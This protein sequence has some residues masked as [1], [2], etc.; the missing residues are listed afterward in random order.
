[1]PDNSLNENSLRSVSW[2][3]LAGSATLHV[4][5]VMG[6]I[7]TLWSNHFR[8]WGALTQRPTDEL[9]RSIEDGRPIY[10]GLVFAGAIALGVTAGLR[11]S[12]SEFR[13]VGI[14][15]AII[16]FL[17]VVI[18]LTAFGVQDGS[19]NDLNKLAPHSLVLL[20]L[21]ALAPFAL[22]INDMRALRK[23]PKER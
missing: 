2:F 15:S 1:M 17:P 9:A 18:E 3:W 16:A 11:L 4:I 6:T 13:E 19:P 10:F 20:A 8:S 14:R 21:V 5:F 12:R 7:S 23:P 22:V